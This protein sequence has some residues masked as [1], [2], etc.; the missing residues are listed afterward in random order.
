MR[1]GG[2]ALLVLLGAAGVLVSGCGGDGSGVDGGPTSSRE[3]PRAA[4]S[5]RLEQGCEELNADYDHLA[6]ADPTDRDA[7]VDHAEDVEAYTDELV[8]LLQA[9]GVPDE[10]RE[11]AERVVEL[12]T[13]LSDAAT[14]LATAAAEGDEDAAGR[15]V[16]RMTAAGEAINPLAD[17]L[18]APAC[19]G[20]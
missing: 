11:D 2:R 9:S 15:A 4:W 5:E 7:A 1:R 14:D 17:S 19:G 12:A 18:D 16:E 3:V 10:D 20:F 8:E 13:D 6:S